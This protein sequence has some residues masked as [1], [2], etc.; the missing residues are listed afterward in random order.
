[1][2][3][4]RVFALA[5]L[6]SSR[7]FQLGSSHTEKG[8]SWWPVAELVTQVSHPATHDEMWILA[9]GGYKLLG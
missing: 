3:D 5:W 1:M 6:L 7:L 4:L 9:W 2:I 8:G